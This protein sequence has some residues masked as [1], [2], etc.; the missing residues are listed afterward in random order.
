M[1]NKDVYNINDVVHIDL[2]KHT[3]VHTKTSTRVKE[4]YQE[5]I[6][7]YLLGWSFV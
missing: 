1:L 4:S 5:L 2:S 7:E 3:V 6:T